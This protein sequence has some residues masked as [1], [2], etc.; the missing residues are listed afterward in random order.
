MNEI[1][2]NT[3]LSLLWI[4]VLINMLF[5]DIFSIMIELVNRNTLD[6]PGDVRTVMAVAAI[7]TNVPILMIYLSRVLPYR[8]N[9]LANIIAAFVTI[10]YVVGGGDTAPHYLIVASIEV[11]LLIMI[12]VRAY[13]WHEGAG[14]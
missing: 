14:A 11:V 7:V 1:H 13:K 10:I 6:I 2:I 3:R 12:I 4:V 5:A 8:I 9:R